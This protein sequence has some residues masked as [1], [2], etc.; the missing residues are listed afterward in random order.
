MHTKPYIGPKLQYFS[1]ERIKAATDTKRKCIGGNGYGKSI[2]FQGIP[3]VFNSACHAPG[4]G[5]VLIVI[6][7]LL[8]LI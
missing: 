1:A 3:V 4:Q 6:S 7:S 5:H 2:I 8:A